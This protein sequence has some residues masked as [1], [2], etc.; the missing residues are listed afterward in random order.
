MHQDRRR[1]LDR[2]FAIDAAA[3]VI[4]GI[5]A[6]ITPHRAIQSIADPT[7]TGGLSSYNHA[8]HETLR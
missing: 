1:Q 6:L 4:F 3:S 7:G 5:L 2:L 8:A